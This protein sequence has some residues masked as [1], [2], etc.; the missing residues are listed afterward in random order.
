[1]CVCVLQADSDSGLLLFCGESDQGEGDYASLAL[2]HGR[3]HFRFNCGTGSGH[4]VSGRRVTPGRWHTVSIA[5]VGV[6][7]WL[8]LD[9]DTP[10]TGR[11]QVRSQ[12]CRGGV[13]LISEESDVQGRNQA[14]SQ[15][16]R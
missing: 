14:R 1:M 16:H 7:G 11:S 5:R 10:V 4:M 8:R 3:L 2:I 15:T 13:K 9:N 12:T 6:T